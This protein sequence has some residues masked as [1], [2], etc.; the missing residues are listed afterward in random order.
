MCLSGSAV[1]FASG[2]RSGLHTKVTGPRTFGQGQAHE[3]VALA[4]SSSEMTRETPP[5]TGGIS[6]PQ[7]YLHL[8]QMLTCSQFRSSRHLFISTPQTCSQA[9]ANVQSN[10]KPYCTGPR[11]T[12]LVRVTRLTQNSR[13]HSPGKVVGGAIRGDS[14]QNDTGNAHFPNCMSTQPLLMFPCCELRV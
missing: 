1:D 12:W 9:G 4:A 5:F 7:S 3:R 13:A 10:T 14:R 2:S 11:A 6:H 8:K